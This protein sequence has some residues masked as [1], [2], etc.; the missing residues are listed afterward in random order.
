MNQYNSTQIKLTF[1]VPSTCREY[2]ILGVQASRV[3]LLPLDTFLSMVQRLVKQ[4][5]QPLYNKL[6]TF[7]LQQEGEQEEEVQVRGG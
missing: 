1:I 2:G 5:N 4:D 7:L 3:S 6:K